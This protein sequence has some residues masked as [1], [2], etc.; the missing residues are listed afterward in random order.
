MTSTVPR[1]A[2]KNHPYGAGPYKLKEF[3]IGN[4][5][6]LEKDPN[7]PFAKPNGPDII[8]IRKMAEAEQRVDGFVEW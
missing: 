6:V 8:I 3:V 1:E 5:M 2:D 4:R 7:N